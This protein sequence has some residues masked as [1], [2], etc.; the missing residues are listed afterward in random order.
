[1]PRVTE[2]RRAKPPRGPN[3]LEAKL[4]YARK[5]LSDLV[6]GSSAARRDRWIEFFADYAA[7]TNDAC[8]AKRLEVLLLL[9]FSRLDED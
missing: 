3:P 9:A 5:E 1:M 7:R 8:A 4:Q 6:K 2:I